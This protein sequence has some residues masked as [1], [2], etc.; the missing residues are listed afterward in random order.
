MS[1][2]ASAPATTL[3]ALGHTWITTSKPLP[4]A[5][6]APPASPPSFWIPGNVTAEP[7]GLQLALERDSGVTWEGQQAWA[8]AQAVL[9]RPQGKILGYGT[10]RVTVRAGK[11]SDTGNAAWDPFCGPNTTAA[12]TSTTF[13]AFTFDPTIAAPF[14]EIDLVEIGYQNQNQAGGWINQQP[15]VSASNNAQFALQPWDAAVSGQ[16]D[17][18]QV[19]RIALESGSLPADGTVTFLMKWEA[20]GIE[21]YAAYGTHT[22][23][24]FPFTG[25]GTQ[26]WT[27]TGTPP[28]P[29]HHTSLYLNLWAYGGPTTNAPVHFTVTGVEVPLTDA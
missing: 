4:P 18:G 11:A 29:T 26:R 3:S 14:N 20:G 9:Q 17:W 13:G 12:N 2:L 25:H 5:T 7:G 1:S 8:A 27:T 28:A 21:F 23:A 22:A 19:H 24:A 6:A 10:Y 16:P 15:G